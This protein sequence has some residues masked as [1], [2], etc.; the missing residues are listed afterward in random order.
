MAEIFPGPGQ[1]YATNVAG[2]HIFNATGHPLFTQGGNVVDPHTHAVVPVNGTTGDPEDPHGAAIAQPGDRVAAFTRYTAAAGANLMALMRPVGGRVATAPGRASRGVIDYTTK[3]GMAVYSQAT[4]ALFDGSE[5]CPKFGMGG[6]GLLGLV[7]AVKE[8]AKSAGWDIFE[9][10]WTPDGA[11][12]AITKNLLTNYG[13]IPL[14]HVITAA[15]NI[16]NANDRTTQE[17]HQ[18]YVCLSNSLTNS[19]KTT[20]NLHQ[21]DY[22]VH[23]EYSGICF[24][25]VI[26][27]EAQ[28]D[29]RNTNNRLLQQLTSGMPNIMGRHGNN[30]KA[31]NEE[32]QSILKRIQARGCTAGSLVPQLLSTYAGVEDDGSFHRFIERIKDDYSRGREDFTELE[33]MAAAQTKYEEL[34][35]E[36]KFKGGSKKED[37]IVSLTAQIKAMESKLEEVGRNGTRPNPKKDKKKEG[38]K[39]RGNLEDWVW[40]PPKEGESHEKT[41]AG[42]EKPWYWCPGH[43]EHKPRWVR[44]LPAECEGLKKKEKNEPKSED[45]TPKSILKDKSAKDDPSKKG[46]GWSTGML[47]KIRSLASDSDSDE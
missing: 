30:I 40:V 47:A 6:D 20:L 22:T 9:I 18:L 41:L 7:D 5:D 21:K 8:R 39:K 29:T 24:L 15:D 10:T 12:A 36:N 28:I 11:T 45:K 3:E 17:D 32:V 2:A 26:M 38:G 31:F 27:R 4:K 43:G 35:E 16:Y 19:A 1:G 33:L 23:G 37:A 34:V 46:V 13:E 42:E 25:R 14:E 44:H